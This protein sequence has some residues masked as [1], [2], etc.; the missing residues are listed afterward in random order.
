VVVVTVAFDRGND[1][2]SISLTFFL[3]KTMDLKV[4]EIVSPGTEGGWPLV[5][6][7]GVLCEFHGQG[8]PIVSHEAISF[9]FDRGVHANIDGHF[10]L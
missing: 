5:S 2:N 10:L 4:F 8:V 3:W 7:T 6:W 9:I 1:D